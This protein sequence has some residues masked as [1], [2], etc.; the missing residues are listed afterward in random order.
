MHLID[1][2]VGAGTDARGGNGTVVHLVTKFR[3]RHHHQKTGDGSSVATNDVDMDDN[4]IQRHQ[5]ELNKPDE[6][7]LLEEK[8]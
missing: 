6:D 8:V 3:Q 5:N 1:V 2:E 4:L 7:E